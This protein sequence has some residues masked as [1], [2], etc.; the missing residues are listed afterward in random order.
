MSGGERRG[1]E[2]FQKQQVCD[3]DTDVDRQKSDGIALHR[4]AGKPHII[5]HKTRSFNIKRWDGV[6]CWT[7]DFSFS[8]H[9]LCLYSSLCLSLSLSCF[10]SLPL[11]TVIKFDL[12]VSILP[13][14]SPPQLPLPLSALYVQYC[15]ER[16]GDIY[17][18]ESYSVKT[19][20]NA[21]LFTSRQQAACPV[22]PT[23][24]LWDPSLALESSQ[25]QLS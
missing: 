8:F 21:I 1:G 18:L 6:Q 19:Q 2:D 5:Q 15:V 14:F 9:L 4:K 16:N 23:L 20:C 17:Y 13:P 24:S 12:S 22:M 25:V 10:F 7:G 3:N 11:I